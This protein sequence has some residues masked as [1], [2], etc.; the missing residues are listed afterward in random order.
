MILGVLP[1]IQPN[2]T[3]TKKFLINGDVKKCLQEKLEDLVSPNAK[4]LYLFLECP[5]VPKTK[6]PK[7]KELVVEVLNQ[8]APYNIYICFIFTDVW[9]S[10]FK[11]LDYTTDDKNNARLCTIDLPESRFADWLISY[12]ISATTGPDNLP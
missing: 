7:P 10:R 6:R 3:D 9:N 11:L 2:A 1:R 4:S 5:Q 12:R 8:Y